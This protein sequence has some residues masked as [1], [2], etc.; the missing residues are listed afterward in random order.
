MLNCVLLKER[1]SAVVGAQETRDFAV[2][3]VSQTLYVAD[4]HRLWPQGSDAPPLVPP[5]CDGNNEDSN[6][7]IVCVADVPLAG[8]LGCAMRGGRVLLWREGAAADAPAA[9]TVDAAGIAACAWSPDGRF[10]AVLGRTGLLHVLA[11]DLAPVVAASPAV[12]AR[13]GWRADT[14]AVAA[15]AIS[16]R[17]DSECFSVAAA[18][19]EQPERVQI[20]VVDRFGHAE[21]VCAVPAAC[22]TQKG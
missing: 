22:V 16:W 19:A 18:A 17:G 20:A 1:Q 9:A 4:R 15:A 3:S 6:D 11:D 21:A 13:L 10:C 7:E 5:P 2:E 12:R 8:G 14:V